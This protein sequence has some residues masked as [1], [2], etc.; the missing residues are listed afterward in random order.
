MHAS[1]YAIAEWWC[2]LWFRPH[3]QFTCTTAGEHSAAPSVARVGS[4]RSHV[5]DRS[6][7][8]GLDHRTVRL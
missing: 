2:T 6:P 1:A 7:S 3:A 8:G 5:L 4:R